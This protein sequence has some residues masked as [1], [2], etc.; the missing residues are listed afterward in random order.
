MHEVL[1]R[2]EG[3]YADLWRRQ[4]DGFITVSEFKA[5]L[6]GQAGRLAV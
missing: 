4:K 3:I 1:L 2:A 6:L 5:E